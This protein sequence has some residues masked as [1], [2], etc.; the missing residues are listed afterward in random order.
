MALEL[1]CGCFINEKPKELFGETRYRYPYNKFW[2]IAKKTGNTIIVGIDAHS[3]EAFN[4][5]NITLMNQF[6]KEL[7]LK[8][9]TKL[10]I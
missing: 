3:P 4:S 10:D 1:N 5:N 8:I 6:I 7:D 9:T 2:Q